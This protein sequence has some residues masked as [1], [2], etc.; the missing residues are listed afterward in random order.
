[1][2]TFQALPCYR[3]SGELGVSLLFLWLGMSLRDR[4]LP[5]NCSYLPLHML[6][7]A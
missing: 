7:K 2:D 4:K 5:D 3:Y 1:M 6:L